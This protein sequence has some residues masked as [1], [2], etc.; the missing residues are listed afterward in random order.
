MRQLSGDLVLAQ[1]EMRDL[2]IHYSQE[3]SELTT[4]KEIECEELQEQLSA[5]KL[6]YEVYKQ[7]HTT[8]QE[9]TS[10]TT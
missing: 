8:S 9:E 1:S 7:S 2:Q 4:S 10:R 3:L 6:E 5:L